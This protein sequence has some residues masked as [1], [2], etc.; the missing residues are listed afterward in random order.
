MSLD[1]N[2]INWHDFFIY[3]ETSKSGIRWKVDVEVFTRC[4]VK[5]GDEAGYQ[6]DHGRYS[7]GFNNKRYMCH[8]IIW[9]MFN[10]SI[11]KNLLIDH[12]DRNA[13]NNKISN[14]R[15]VTSSINQ[16]NM[17]KNKCNTSGKTGVTIMLNKG[18]LYSVSFWNE[19][20]QV[21]TKYFSVS[22]LGLL[23]SFAKACEHRDLKIKELNEQGY[24][25]T[26]NH[27]K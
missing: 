13:S 19:K 6:R 18:Y 27:G 24:G 1:Y 8:R 4:L 5:A 26:E 7:V 20:G 14:L 10:G 2:S 15:A 16:R 21:R 3:D 25:Y 9:V 23:E 12:I 22:K 17:S 11:D